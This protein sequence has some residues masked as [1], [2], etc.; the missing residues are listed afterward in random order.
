MGDESSRGSELGVLNIE[1]EIDFSDVGEV[2]TFVSSLSSEDGGRF[3]IP[4]NSSFE[5][6]SNSIVAMILQQET[7]EQD[8]N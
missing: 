5:D 7:E 6:K 1:S 8:E 4:P 3:G 2:W